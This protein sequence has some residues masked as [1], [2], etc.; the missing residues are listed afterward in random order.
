MS[1]VLYIHIKQLVNIRT[2][3]TGPLRGEEMKYLP[4]LEN[5]WLATEDNRI[6]S[7]GSMDEWEGISDWRNLEVVDCTGSLVMPAFVDAHTHLIFAG[8][9]EKEFADRLNGLSYE[10]IAARGGG[11]LNSADRLREASFQELLNQGRQRLQEIMAQGTLAVEIKSGYGL[12][13]DS[14]LTILRVIK[15]L[16][17][18]SHIPI[19]ATLL[20]AHAVPREYHGNKDQWIRD[21]IDKLLPQVAAE[22]L[23]D[24][25][26]IFCERNYFDADDVHEI[27]T[28]ARKLGIGAKVHANQL[29]HSGGIQAGVKAHAISVDHLEFVDEDDLR[30][31]AN[32]STVPVILPGAQF[33]LQLPA[34]P[35]RAMIDAQLPVALASDYNPGSCP[36]GNLKLLCSM[37]AIMYKLTPEEVLN[38]ATLNAAY[39]IGLEQEV[40]SITPGKR[41]NLIITE[42][43]D[44][45]TQWLYYFGAMG[46][47]EVRGR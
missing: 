15:Q 32:S 37:A 6:L 20:A 5:A 24:Y 23:A 13:I 38:A 40:G 14:E 35:V 34:P 12:S 2:Q 43:C 17:Q 28:A 47:R 3:D 19:K 21:I 42:P 11:I 1:R 41:A 31:L 36:T 10:E 33:F 29:S 4:V 16:K 46:I 25:C 22:G 45:Y 8:S 39:A 44:N 27:M 9:R 26:D 30:A 7:W 18:E